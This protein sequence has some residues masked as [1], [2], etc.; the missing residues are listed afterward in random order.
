[1]RFPE[2]RDGITVT[3]LRRIIDFTVHVF[4]A[5]GANQWNKN[6]DLKQ[7]SIE[8]LWLIALGVIHANGSGRKDPLYS[9][10]VPTD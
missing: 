9:G 6:N 5:N 3:D 4:T 10:E 1:M 8:S 2:R 7:S